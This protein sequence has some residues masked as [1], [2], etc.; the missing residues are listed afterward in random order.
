MAFEH[1]KAGV[2]KHERI[3]LD[4]MSRWDNSEEVTMSTTDL[5]LTAGVLG[6]GGSGVGDGKSRVNYYAYGVH[7]PGSSAVTI[8]YEDEKGG[9]G[10]TFTLGI[11]AYGWA[12]PLVRLTKIKSTSAGT[13]ASKIKI[14]YKDKYAIDGTGPVQS[15][16]E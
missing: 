7:N 12:Q 1:G 11:A 5:D 10:V 13:S 14:M 2:T 15:I 9:A 4:R 8:K 3:A 6:D 16:T